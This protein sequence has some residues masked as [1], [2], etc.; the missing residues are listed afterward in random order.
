MSTETLS[1]RDMVEQL[2]PNLSR[3]ARRELGGVRS[4]ARNVR[5]DQG[6]APELRQ[7]DVALDGERFL[8]IRTAQETMRQL[9]VVLN[10]DEELKR[11]VP[12]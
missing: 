6:S 5:G 1:Y 8:M 9:K 12:R 10:F 3:V 11:R 7:G 4:F 2:P